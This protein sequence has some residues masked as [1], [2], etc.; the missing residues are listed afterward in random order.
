VLYQV[1]SASTSAFANYHTSSD[2]RIADLFTQHQLTL[3]KSSIMGKKKDFR[4][5]KATNASRMYPSLHHNV[6]KAVFEDIG[7]TRFHDNDSS[8]GSSK[9][10]STFVMGVFVCDNNAC[11]EVAWSSGKI[12]LLVR[13]YP[14]HGYNAV[15][16]GQRCKSCQ[17]LGR[18]KLDEQS[19][20][21]RVSYRLKR[22]AGVQME[23][24]PF[25]LKGTPP[26]R[27][28]LCEGCK[29]G[30]CPEVIRGLYRRNI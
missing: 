9:E 6:A 30:C 24:P 18:L 11:S 7:T 3:G 29:R 15:V 23:L 17:R 14:D 10:Y 13:K 8:E 5:K 27:V 19:Y 4:L 20:I 26:H 28:E 21:D 16:F 12:T 2:S 1:L 25:T 22:W